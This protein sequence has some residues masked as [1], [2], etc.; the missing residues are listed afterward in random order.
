MDQELL[1]YNRIV[2]DALRSVVRTALE[3]VATYGLPG[4]HNLYV[5]FDTNYPDVDIPERLDQQYPEEMTVVL[6][7]Q[8]W[9]LHVTEEHFEV[10]LSF[11]RRRERLSIPF[12]AV[13]AFADP[14]V[15]FG[16]KFQIAEDEDATPATPPPPAGD[17]DGAPV[18]PMPKPAGGASATDKA[19][20]AGGPK[21]ANEAEEADGDAEKDATGEVVSLDTFRK[22]R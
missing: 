15:P 14:S 5:T 12:A 8:F 3:Q 10:T 11:N 9:D 21:G 17:Q 18:M 20:E 22:N 1:Q 6:E 13:T 7:H 19:G 2:E 16:L 4:E